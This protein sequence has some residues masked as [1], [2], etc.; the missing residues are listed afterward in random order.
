MG[1]KGASLSPGQEDVF[2]YLF[3][4]I[5]AAVIP[6]VKYEGQD[7]FRFGASSGPG[8]TFFYH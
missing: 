7:A 2:I 5:L 3:L 4:A 6:A 1:I 8:T